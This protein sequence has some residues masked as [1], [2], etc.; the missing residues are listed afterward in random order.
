MEI[1]VYDSA[2]QVLFFILNNTMIL[3]LLLKCKQINQISIVQQNSNKSYIISY[4]IFFII[5]IF[6]DI[7]KIYKLVNNDKMER[8]DKV[9]FTVLTCVH[10]VYLIIEIIIIG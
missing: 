6:A 1:E 9:I 10:L 5:I 4:H 2:I 8:V 7:I 3:L